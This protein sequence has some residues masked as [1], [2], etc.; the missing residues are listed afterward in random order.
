MHSY[1]SVFP[2]DGCGFWLGV[3]VGPV[4]P[5][6]SWCLNAFRESAWHPSASWLCMRCCLLMD[7]EFC[8]Y[9]SF[10]FCIHSVCHREDTHLLNLIWP[11]S[12]S[13]LTVMMEEDKLNGSLSISHGPGGSHTICVSPDN[14]CRSRD[15]LIYREGGR[16]RGQ[17][18]W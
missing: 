8:E 5:P 6:F 1:S 3:G 16:T 18:P 14:H 17:G 12:S 11:N 4:S 9:V 2:T 7:H 15:P 10:S 13:C